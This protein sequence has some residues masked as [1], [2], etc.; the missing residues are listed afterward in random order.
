MTHDITL[1]VKNL[2]KSSYS[3]GC[4]CSSWII[5]RYTVIIITVKFA[6]KRT[7]FNYWGSI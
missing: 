1:N 3:T 7:Y 2:T 6:Y 4:T 5:Y